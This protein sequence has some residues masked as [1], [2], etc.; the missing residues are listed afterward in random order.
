MTPSRYLLALNLFQKTC[1][2][3]GGGGQPYG[4]YMQRLAQYIRRNFI[5]VF[6]YEP[7]YKAALDCLND[8]YNREHLEEFPQVLRDITYVLR[9]VRRYGRSRALIERA[10]CYSSLLGADSLRLSAALFL[11]VDG[12]V[13]LEPEDFVQRPGDLDVVRT[14]RGCIFAEIDEDLDG[15]EEEITIFVATPYSFLLE[16]EEH[17]SQITSE[18][19]VLGN[20]R[21]VTAQVISGR[22][23]QL[24]IDD[25]SLQTGQTGVLYVS[26]TLKHRDGRA[27]NMS[28]RN[29]EVGEIDSLLIA[30]NRCI[31]QLTELPAFHLSYTV[32]SAQGI[33][34]PAQVE[35]GLSYLNRLFTGC[36]KGNSTNECTI[37]AYMQALNKVLIYS[38]NVLD[39]R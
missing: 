26:V 33:P 23:S 32:H 21:S 9:N 3:G 5:R 25:W 34:S 27:A 37:N 14:G 31:E 11:S 20:S 16:V 17:I 19:A 29:T 6:M 13:S 30:I 28:L 15:G 7:D 36:C 4:Y 18:N 8:P 10:R 1:L 39:S 38:K 35:I 12:I 22:I 2:A 24:Y